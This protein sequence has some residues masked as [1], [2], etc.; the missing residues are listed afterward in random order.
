MNEQ[1]YQIGIRD[2]SKFHLICLINAYRDKLREFQ[3]FF[4]DEELDMLI[5][6][7]NI[8]LKDLTNIYL[9]NKIKKKGEV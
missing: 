3:R 6:D 8:A 1:E 9:Y 7:Y 2:L 5:T 4:E